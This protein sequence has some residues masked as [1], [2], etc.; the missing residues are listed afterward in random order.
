M[1]QIEL[2]IKV[3]ELKEMYEKGQLQLYLKGFD[4]NIISRTEEW[5]LKTKSSFLLS[6]LNKMIT[7]QIYIYKNEYGGLYVIDSKNRATSYIIR[8]DL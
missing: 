4:K 2:S 6:I 5:D 1:H 8:K 7:P 3:S